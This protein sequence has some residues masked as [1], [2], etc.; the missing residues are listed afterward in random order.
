MSAPIF[1]LRKQIKTTA[2]SEAALS[3]V[4][5][6]LVRAGV[7]W[8]GRKLTQEAIVNASWLLLAGMEDAALVSAMREY[9]PRLEDLMTG[10]P[11]PVQAQVERTTRPPARTGADREPKRRKSS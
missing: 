10:T 4:V 11:G 6:R 5:A 3:E 7:R 8:K 2:E 9:L 1:E